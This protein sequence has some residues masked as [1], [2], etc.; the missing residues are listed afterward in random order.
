MR[1]INQFKKGDIDMKYA[2]YGVNRVTKDFLY[3]FN[4]LEVVCIL[5]NQSEV[6]EFCGIKVLP[7]DMV[8]QNYDK[9]IVCD[10]D[11]TDKIKYLEDK[12]LTYGQDFL[13][14]RDFFE[15]LNEGVQFNED[16][17]P[18]VVWGIGK[19]ADMFHSLNIK[20]NVEFYIDNYK[21][22]KLYNGK[23][24]LKSNNI[25]NLNQYFIIIAVADD[26]EI[27]QE[28]QNKGMKAEKDYLNFADLFNKIPSLALERTIFDTSCYDVSCKTMLT[29]IEL[30][31]SG[32]VH[33]CCSTFMYFGMGKASDKDLF[34]IWNSNIH[35][36]MCLSL[37]NKTFSFCKKD[38]CPLFV[39]KKSIAIKDDFIKSKYSKMKE[40]P[41]TA[42]LAFDSTCN[43]KC[44]S[45]RDELKVACGENLQKVEKYSKL[46]QEQL[47]P[48]I[49]FMTLAGDGE[50]FFSKR[51][52]DIYLNDKVAKIK[53]IRL[54]TNGLL[55]NEK[56]WNEFYT[57]KT[58]KIMLTVSIDAAT[59]ETYESIRRNGNFKVLQENMKFA[60]KLR[61][62]GKL[63]Y[64]R[65]NFV[66]QKKNYLEMEH[67]VKWGLEL[68]VDEVFFTKILNWG[69]Y[70]PDEFR[71]ISMMQ[72]DG[73]TPKP[74]LA[75]IL[76]KQI[77][78]NSIVDLGTIQ[79]Q[80]Y[81]VNQDIDNYYK[82]ELERKIPD[83][84]ID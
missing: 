15:Q 81:E 59:K 24:V 63:S 2:I 77:M 46:V 54:L 50:V 69:T 3:I 70:S 84:F 61:K 45:C 62:E 36:I 58:G 56:N 53:W 72:E 60:S 73:V 83:L 52:K 40:H 6:D 37:E 27:V 14:E 11:K 12:G 25:S 10:F 42:I 38:M 82:W 75:E 30:L 33:C 44:I 18:V 66:V 47:I 71:E 21:E 1:L 74:E 51:Y 78:Q 80:H 9:I 43:L 8:N 23:K 35:K 57:N 5:E 28:L 39:N 67:F 16:G 29:N 41:D 49:D 68:G 13:Y 31:S 4:T 65:I 17:K 34:D 76:N 64:F 32:V 7:F 20:I 55:F 26:S 48:Y 22:V 79:C 19:W